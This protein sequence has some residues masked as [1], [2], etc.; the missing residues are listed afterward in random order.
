MYVLLLI[1]SYGCKILDRTKYKIY[2]F[3]EHYIDHFW[4]LEDT[5]HPVRQIIKN[6]SPLIFINYKNHKNIRLPEIELS[7]MKAHKKLYYVS[8][9]DGFNL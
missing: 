5:L 1:A 3:L 9:I 8:S 4:V 6:I 7:P 2:F